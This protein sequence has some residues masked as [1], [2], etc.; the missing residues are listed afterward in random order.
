M[1]LEADQWLHRRL[2]GVM[3]LLAVPLTWV[4]LLGWNIKHL[5]ECSWYAF[6]RTRMRTSA[7]APAT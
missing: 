3:L 1:L 4:S 5:L 7:T 2:A 6:C